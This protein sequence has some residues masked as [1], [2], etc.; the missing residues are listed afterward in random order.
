MVSQKIIEQRENLPTFEFK[1]EL[2]EAIREY[3]VLVVIGE[4]GSGKTTQIPQYILEGMPEMKK[5]GVTQPRRIAAITVAKRVSEEQGVRL[6]ATVGYTIRFD[7]TT[8]P[9][10]KLKY[11]TDGVLLREAT[12][13]PRLSQYSVVVI[14]EAHERTLE[15]DVLFGLLKKTRRLRPDLKILIM[16]ATLDVEKFSDFFEECP[17]FEIPGRTFPVDVIY[18]KDAQRLASLKSNLVDHAVEA[19]WHI[20]TQEPAGDLLVF[21]TGQNDIERA[22]RAFQERAGTSDYKKTVRFYDEGVRDIA[23]YPLYASLET[24]DQKAVFEAPRD[25]VRK[26]VFATNVAQTSVTIPGIRYVIDSGFVKEKTYDATTGMDALLVTEI[27]QAAATQRAGRAGRT[28]PGKAYRLYTP[29][30]F[31]HML[32]DTIPEIQRSSL[33]GTVLSL[34]K[35][36]IV[37]VVNFEFIDPPD[38]KLVRNALKQ[39]YLL[40]AIDEVGKLTPLG[41]K[42][43]YF[44]LSPSLARVLVSSAEEYECSNEVLTIASILAGENDLFRAPSARSR[45]G[46]QAVIEAEECKLRFAHHAGDH[47][48]YLNVWHEWKRHSKSRSWCK[49]NWINSKVLETAANV[50]RQLVDVMD[51]ARLPIKRAPR[52][53]QETKSSKRR[54]MGDDENGRQV[55]PVPVLKSFLSGYFTNIANKGAHRAV[56]SHYSPDQHLTE[57]MTAEVNDFTGSPTSLVALHLHPLCAF[58]DMLDRNRIR[59]S[60]LD[61]V[62]YMH[63]TYTNKAVMKGVSKILWEWIKAGEG[64]ER[65][66]KLAK[67]RLNGEDAPNV[68]EMDHDAEAEKAKLEDEKIMEE[69]EQDK[70]KRRAAEIEEIRQRALAR[71]KIQ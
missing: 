21:L 58:S 69:I 11:M 60:E 37:D 68:L 48:T 38:E 51:K 8:S 57:G 44:P 24:Y 1:N 65:I 40:G 31:N 17:I 14:D 3:S 70:R 43:S 35:M 50:R 45:G 54:A 61:W 71:R 55:D 30:S 7:D 15:T 26:V 23:I 2:V 67:T 62:M 6:G 39:L 5:I 19:A 4:T 20:H 63:V 47:M 59:Y 9:E 28:A 25:G 66:R 18:Y 33:L 10:T 27:S 52:W 22:C 49:D 12:E 53:K 46:Q 56:F 29:D 36:G 13:D 42:M 16:S 34:K 32:V 64:R 41:D